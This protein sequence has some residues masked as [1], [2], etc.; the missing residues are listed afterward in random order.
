M[1]LGTSLKSLLSRQR[2]TT[3]QGGKVTGLLLTLALLLS[4]PGSYAEDIE[5][6]FSDSNSSGQA[7]I[8]ILLD[9]SGS[10]GWCGNTT[11]S[12]GDASRTRMAELKRSFT[13][14]IDG[15]GGTARIG[16][17]RLNGQDGGY[18]L[19][20]VKA[21]DNPAAELVVN[22]TISSRRDDANQSTSS[23]ADL[24]VTDNV[25]NFPNGGTAGGRSGL[26]FRAI[27]VPRYAIISNATLRVQAAADS[28]APLQVAANYEV[29]AALDDFAVTSLFNR[30]WDD[31]TLGVWNNP[32]EFTIPGSD[33]WVAGQFYD[34][35]ITALLQKAVDDELWCAGLDIA[36]G[37]TDADLSGNFRTI[38]ARDSV[39][40]NGALVEPQLD[41]EWEINTAINPGP[42]VGPAYE[43][44]LSC[45]N[46]ISKGTSNSSDDGDQQGARVDLDN[47]TLPVDNNGW[48]AY[49]FPNIQFDPNAAT[50]PDVINGGVL[51]FS[52]V[53]AEYAE[54]TRQRR[55]TCTRY[56]NY[57]LTDGDVTLEITGVVGD[58]AALSTRNNDISTRSVVPTVITYNT[59][60]AA[61]DFNS[62]HTIDVSAMVE[63]MMASGW[64]QGGALMFRIRATDANGR[65]F[66]LGAQEGGAAN[67]A[68]LRLSVSTADQTRLVPL[69]R[70]RLKDI[71]NALPA[72][73]STPLAEAYTE[74]TRYM[75]GDSVDWGRGLS[76]AESTNGAGTAYLSPSD[77]ANQECSSNHIVLMT[78][79]EPNSDASADNGVV[80][81]TGETI[82]GA[83]SP[84]THAS[85]DDVDSYEDGSLDQSMACMEILAGWNRNADVN[86]IEKEVNTHMVLFYLDDDAKSEADEVVAAGG[87]TAVLAESEEELQS[88]FTD[89]INSVTVQNGTL[90]APG[91]AVNR[92]NRLR[93]LSQLYYALFKPSTN[94]NWEGNMKRYALQV[95]V[96]DDGNSSSSIVDEAGDDA[97]NPAT[98]FFRVDSNSW[99]GALGDGTDPDDGSD[100]ELGG[101]RQE[102]ELSDTSRSLYVPVATAG[103]YSD[104]LATSLPSATDSFLLASNADTTA[105][106]L[107]MDPSSTTDEI[108]SRVE[109][110]LTAW[111]DPLH[112]EPRLVNYGLK[113][114]ATVEEAIVDPDKQDNVI[115]VATNM[116]AVHAIDPIDGSELF[117]FMP[118]EEL[119][120]TDLR[121]TNPVVPPDALTRSTYGLDGGI[122]V[123]RKNRVGSPDPEH[124]LL[125]VAQRRGGDNIFA[126]DASNLNN[127]RMLWNINSDD[128]DFS[129]LGQSWSQPVLTQVRVDGNKIPVLVF[130]GGYDATLNDDA[131]TVNTADVVGNSI[132]VVNAYTGAL[133]WSASNSG[134]DINNSD[135]KWSIPAP[136]SVVDN[137]YDGVA[138]YFYAVDMGGQ[139]FRVDLDESATNA[140]EIAHRVATFA[141]LGTGETGATGLAD[142]RRFYSQPSVIL[143]QRDGGAVMLQVAVGSGYRAHPLEERNSDRFY[144]LDDVDALSAKSAGFTP[145]AAYETT[146]LVDVTTDLSPAASEFN[147]KNGWDIDLDLGEKVLAPAVGVSGTVF[148]STYLPTSN[149]TNP[150]ASVVG[151]SRLYAVK[152]LDGSPAVDFDDLG[153][154][155]RSTDLQLAGLPPAPQ[156]LINSEDNLLAIVGTAVV[157]LGEREGGRV[158]RTRWYEVQTK[159]EADAV[160]QRAKDGN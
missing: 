21:L 62:Q 85:C 63:Q 52:G 37:F 33:A 100:V 76:T 108:D 116:G 139:I 156:I 1:A 118:R 26:I 144:V 147:S 17:G 90:A 11:S 142:H 55:G 75:Q 117:S 7:N 109:L 27:N 119:E 43:S 59:S 57:D 42:A 150:C 32:V 31:Q 137:N 10:M 93:H 136:I 56:R 41:L 128:S 86:D 48:A 40:D 154:N 50:R 25:T 36:L 53:R 20:P 16:L 61:V 113:G 44:Q 103:N 8:M 148:F 143:N 121:Y 18:I 106:M 19:H 115:F 122:T 51:T 92:F 49:R 125:Y 91:I 111:G 73:G 15:L 13:R 107:G 58:A 146:D 89:I 131:D 3:A 151:A 132:Y 88:A 112:G 97:V 66:E 127:P 29:G 124:V 34:I 12:C 159:A 80:T 47:S 141:K 114:G 39:T 126:I 14:L 152:A 95:D 157:E 74:M 46:T 140:S 104:E 102:L 60:A 94:S 5:I 23:S 81:I 71:V 105:E 155:S 98:G 69:V 96:D 45:T 149:N 77:D 101:A 84:A 130:G 79:G 133:L 28:S 70:D 78:D 64:T 22:A 2:R 83:D 160:I 6:Y 30:N 134:A 24:F 9:T 4:S 110:L 120:K 67:S 135:M 35:D 82:F 129:N 72:N 123:W 153:G 54:C 87:G 138:D 38:V 99:W 145:S 158:K 68:T 65:F